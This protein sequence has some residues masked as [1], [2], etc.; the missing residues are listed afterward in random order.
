MPLIQISYRSDFVG[1]KDI[2]LLYPAKAPN[3][4]PFHRAESYERPEEK[5]YPV[6]WLLHGGG[7]DFTAWPLNAM[8]LRRCERMGLAVVMPTIQDFLGYRNE[9]GDF[10]RQI[11]EELPEMIGNL[12][13]ISRRREDNFIA[14]LSYGGYLA[15]RIALDHPGNY[16]CVGSFSSPLDCEADL[17]ERHAGQPGFP[18]A[19]E[20]PGSPLDILST[21]ARL[22][23]EGRPM[24]RLFQACGTEDFTWQYNQTAKERFRALGCDHSWFEAPGVH[25]FDFWNLALEKYLDWLPLGDKEG[26]SAL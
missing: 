2:A 4:L 23:A 24:P 26:R 22:K 17:R 8:F 25:N 11:G 6:L 16:A 9:L 21:A 19:W 18:A 12:F 7:D 1:R 3:A 5:R 13:P 14:G 10:Y 20:I 15:Y